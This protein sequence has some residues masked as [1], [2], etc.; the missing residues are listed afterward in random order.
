MDHES[1]KN[2]TSRFSDAHI[3]VV[4]DVMLDKFVWGKVTRI[5]PEAPVPVVDVVRETVV[6]GGA[7]NV[8][9]NICALSGVVYISGVIG[10]DEG[11]EVLTEVLKGKGVETKGLIVDRSRPTT[12]K[13]RILAHSQQVV[14]VDREKREFVDE[15]ILDQIIDYVKPY[16]SKVSVVIISDYGKGIVTPGLLEQLIPLCKEFNTAIIVD[17]KVGHYLSYKGVTLIAPNQDEAQDLTKQV[18]SDED[19]LVNVGRTI[20]RDLGCEAVLITRGE[21]GMTLIEKTG[22]VS[23]VPTAAQEVY[24]VTGAGDTVVSVISLAISVG[25]SIKEA[26]IIANLAAGIVVGKVGTAVVTKDEILGAIER[27]H[28]D[29]RDLK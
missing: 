25:A 4:G 17:P 22:D 18:I 13:T 27:S 14:R 16:L 26:A 5:S 3:L 28:L 20:L 6:P 8:A 1:L 11:G 23:H 21:K 12:L 10:D 15:G 7:A 2:I 19:S 29:F 24:D 9:A